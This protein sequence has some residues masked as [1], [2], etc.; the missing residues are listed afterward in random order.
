VT[1]RPVHVIAWII[2]IIIIIIIINTL[3]G[4]AHY[5]RRAVSLFVAGLPD[6]PSVVAVSDYGKTLTVEWSSSRPGAAGHV[7]YVLQERH[8]V[9]AAYVPERMTAWAT[10]ARTDRTR[11]P[12]KQPPYAPGRWFQFRVAAI[13]ENGTRGYSAPSRPFFAEFDPRKSV[14]SDE[15]GTHNIDPGGFERLMCFSKKKVWSL[16]HEIRCV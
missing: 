14:A 1:A 8:H 16:C 11:E 10:V 2:I 7:T 15:L 6:E 12:L 5:V 9:G 13:N 4:R 3:H